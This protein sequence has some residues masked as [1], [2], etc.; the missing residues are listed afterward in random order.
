MANWIALFEKYKVDRR[1]LDLRLS[2]LSA[3][4]PVS[5]KRPSLLASAQCVEREL[6]AAERILARY[7]DTAISA[8]DALRRADE[9]LFLAYHYICGLTMEKTAL[10][11]CVSRD[12]VYRIRR[13]VVARGEIPTEYLSEEGLTHSEAWKDGDYP[14][15][16][17][18]NV[19]AACF[20]G[21]P[22]GVPPSLD[23]VSG[24]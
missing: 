5:P 9:R 16:P 13:R 21:S 10:A 11:M 22:D 4:S 7:G 20:A 12:S 8:R 23:T 6:H 17:R 14:I 18:S 24:F 1:L 2:E 3:L 19:L 15:E